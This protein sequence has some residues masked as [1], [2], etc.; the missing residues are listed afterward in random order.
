MTPDLRC[1]TVNR[2]KPRLKMAKPILVTQI[3]APAQH[4][5]PDDLNPRFLKIAEFQTAEHQER[6]I[7]RVRDRKSKHK[8]R[9]HSKSGQ[10]NPPDMPKEME[11]PKSS[12]YIHEPVEE[13]ENSKMPNLWN[14]KR[15]NP[16]LQITA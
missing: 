12:A 5:S 10:V 15:P 13:T 14:Q 9:I 3:Q 4:C 1:G 7:K 8:L 11:V 6:F 2:S 16:S